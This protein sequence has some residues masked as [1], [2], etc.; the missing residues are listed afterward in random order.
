MYIY[1]VYTH[2]VCFRR[3][4]SEYKGRYYFF[5]KKKIKVKIYSLKVKK[6][7]VLLFVNH[8]KI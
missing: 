4:R 2:S 5:K 7:N 8:I 6:Q 1:T 3:K